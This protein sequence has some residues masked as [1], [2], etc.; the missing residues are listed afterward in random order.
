MLHDC[1]GLGA[2][3]VISD[4]VSMSGT[5]R[6]LTKTHFE[7]MRNRVTEVRSI[8]WLHGLK[9]ASQGIFNPVKSGSRDIGWSSVMNDS[10]LMSGTLRALTKTHFEH[11][12]DSVTEVSLVGCL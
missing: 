3:N 10:V 12:R 4:K 6:A 11:M 8:G 1:A 9:P 2:S 5:L 7:H